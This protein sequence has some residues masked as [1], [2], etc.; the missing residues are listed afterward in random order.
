MPTYARVKYHA[1]YPGVDLLY[2][3]NQRRLEHDFVVSPGAS[4][5]AV[6][7]S[8]EGAEKLSIDAH[9]DL[10][11]SSKEARVSLNSRLFIRRRRVSSTRSPG[12]TYSREKTRW[13]SR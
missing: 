11:I 2:Y 12:A 5:S 4:P 8:F 1:V 13:A 7:L 6:T 3:G 10:V 9:G